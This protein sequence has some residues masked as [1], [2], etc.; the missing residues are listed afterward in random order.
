MKALLHIMNLI[1]MDGCIKE[2]LLTD[3]EIGSA[4]AMFLLSM[5][6]LMKMQE[7]VFGI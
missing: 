5:M 3:K 7:R 4:K 2:I 6:R 1:K